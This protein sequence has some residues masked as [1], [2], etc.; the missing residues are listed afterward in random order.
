MLRCMRTTIRI[1]DDLLIKAKRK[2]ALENRSLTALIE[3]ALRVALAES[4][5]ERD[6]VELPVSRSTGGVLPGIDLND[7]A[8]LLET[9]ERE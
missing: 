3:E 5:V 1:S 9:L 2:A 8:A 6:P 7:S 4:V